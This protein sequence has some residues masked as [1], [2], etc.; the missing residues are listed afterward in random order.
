MKKKSE[1]TVIILNYNGESYIDKC[2]SSLVKN[3]EDINFEILLVDNASTDSSLDIVRKNFPQVRIIKN[4]E[5]LG[6]SKGNNIGIR[7]S[8]GT[9]CLILNPDTIILPNAVAELLKLIKSYP[10]KA[11]ATGKVLN[12]NGT[13]QVNCRRFPNLIAEYLKQAFFKIKSIENPISNQQIIRTWER[14]EIQNVDWISGCFFITKKSDMLS[15]GGF[16]EK[17]RFYYEDTDLCLRFRKIGGQ[18]IYYPF[19]IIKHKGGGMLSKPQIMLQAYLDDFQS[20]IYYFRKH[21][22]KVQ[23]IVLLWL[24]KATWIINLILLA[25]L[26]ILSLFSIPKIREKGKMLKYMLTRY[27]NLY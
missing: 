22:G 5:N 10:G 20:A 9:Y 16:D 24:T 15:L 18:I 7:A 8:K 2:L 4:Q 3:R 11:I 19:S 14:D 25:L 13:P 6:Y 27:E 17:M 12:F 23:A 21:H 1:L 26:D